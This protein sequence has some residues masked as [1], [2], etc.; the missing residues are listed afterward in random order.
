MAWS[1][2]LLKIQPFSALVDAMVEKG[3]SGPVYTDG[4]AQ[5]IKYAPPP[6][7]PAVYHGH[8][9]FI[10][11]QPLNLM[12]AIELFRERYRNDDYRHCRIGKITMKG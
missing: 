5:L 10:G 3:K 12:N 7:G 6:T 8:R 1:D 2:S 4:G 9:E 11:A